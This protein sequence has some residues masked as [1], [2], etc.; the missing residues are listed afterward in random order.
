MWPSVLTSISI[1]DSLIFWGL[2]LSHGSPM[3]RWGDRERGYRNIGAKLG[4]GMINNAHSARTADALRQLE[5]I[6]GPI[7]I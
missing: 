2:R 1:I 3:P 4:A 7:D 5:L 6:A